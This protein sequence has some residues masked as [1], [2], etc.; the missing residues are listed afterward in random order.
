VAEGRSD[1]EI[2]SVLNVSVRTVAFH[3]INLRQKLGIHTTA[4]LT[5]YALDHGIIAT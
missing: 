2:A 3:K 4:Q 5:K 1:K